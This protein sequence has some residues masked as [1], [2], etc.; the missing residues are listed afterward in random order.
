MMKDVLIE[1][2]KICLKIQEIIKVQQ[3]DFSS[4]VSSDIVWREI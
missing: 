4:R 2:K 1:T 3:S